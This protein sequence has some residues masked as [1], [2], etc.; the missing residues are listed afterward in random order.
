MPKA[1]IQVLDVSGERRGRPQARGTLSEKAI[2]LF[3]PVFL[4][5]DD[6]HT[7]DPEV[8]LTMLN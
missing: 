5:S 7:A 6:D 1:T 3:C 8:F 4:G 2:L